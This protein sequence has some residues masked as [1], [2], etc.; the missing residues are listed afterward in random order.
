MQASD[1]VYEYFGDKSDM[2][3]SSWVES[4]IM[5]ELNFTEQHLLEEKNKL[6]INIDLINNKILE[7]KKEIEELNDE[8]FDWIAKLIIN[9]QAEHDLKFNFLTIR[10]NKQF[11]KNV[12]ILTF[13]R[14]WNHVKNLLLK[15]NIY[16]DIDLI[17]YRFDLSKNNIIINV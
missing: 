4:K 8:E 10:Y 6:L 13:E 11:N 16:R 7:I 3:F 1:R 5:S 9:H 12:N 15:L 17:K 14:T 2:T